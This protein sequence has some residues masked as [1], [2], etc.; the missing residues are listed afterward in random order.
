METE[1]RDWNCRKAADMRNHRR[2]EGSEEPAQGAESRGRAAVRT[3]VGAA[4]RNGDARS[5]WKTAKRTAATER[6]PFEDEEELSAS[7][8]RAEQNAPWLSV[9]AYSL[10]W[11]W[12]HMADTRAVDGH[13]KVE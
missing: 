11:A 12:D 4:L 3:W 10:C 6:T 9:M 13:G 1:A 5:S 2:A 7:R 8:A